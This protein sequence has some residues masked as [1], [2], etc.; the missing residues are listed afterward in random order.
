[1]RIHLCIKNCGKNS[2]RQVIPDLSTH[3]GGLLTDKRVISDLFPHMNEAPNLILTAGGFFPACALMFHIQL[4]SQNLNLGH[5]H[6][7]V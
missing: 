4:V 1:M 5:W 2:Q 3:T 7:V 6:P